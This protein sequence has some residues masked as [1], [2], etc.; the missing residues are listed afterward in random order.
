MNDASYRRQSTTLNAAAVRA[1]CLQR[2]SFCPLADKD[3]DDL[4]P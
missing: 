4:S 1:C 3:G 2:W